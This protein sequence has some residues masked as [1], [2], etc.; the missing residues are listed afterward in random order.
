MNKS[1]AVTPRQLGGFN[2]GLGESNEHLDENAMQSALQQKALAQQGTSAAQST[3]GGSALNM[4]GTAPAAA[5]QAPKPREVGTIPEEL[6]KRSLTDVVKGMQSIFDINVLLGINPEKD[7]PQVQAKKKQTLQRWQKLNNEQRE[8]AQRAYQAK[9]EKEKQQ[10]QQEQMEKQR[11]EKER[12]QQLVMP[13]SVKKGAEGPG[14]QKKAQP[15]AVQ[16]LEQDR[17]TLSGPASAG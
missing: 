13:T 8:V 1:A 4:Q 15:R 6:L 2:Q 10:K 12:S 5:A 7:D 9:I 11:A 14:G 3:T 17:K 16:K